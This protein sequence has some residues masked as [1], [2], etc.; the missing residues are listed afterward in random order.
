MYRKITTT[1][2][3]P[4]QP[5]ISSKSSTGH[6]FGMLWYQGDYLKSLS[7]KYPNWPVFSVRIFS[8]SL[9]VINTPEFI[10]GILGNT[11]SASFYPFHI[12]FTNRAL[13]A[14]QEIKDIVA[15]NGAD[16]RY[17]KAIHH[18]M[19]NA[20]QLGPN[21]VET[22]RRVVHSFSQYFNDID[23]SPQSRKLFDWIKLVYT[24]SLADSFYGPENPIR[25]NPQF[26]KHIWDFEEELP[27]LFL[28][29]FPSITARKAW[30]ARKTLTTAFEEYYNKGLDRNAN[31]FIAGRARAA[32]AE[33]FTNNDLAGFE[34]T[35]CFAALTNTVPNSFSMLCNIFT[36]PALTA[37]IREEVS[38]VVTR[39]SVDGRTV[40]SLDTTS[41]DTSC[42]ILISAYNETLRMCVNATAVRVVMEDMVLKDTYDLKKGGIVQIPGGALHESVR[43][44][45]SDAGVFNG[46]RFLNKKDLGR[47]QRKAQSQG[48]FPFGGGKHLCPGRHLAFSEITSFVAMM[49]YGFEIKMKD[50]GLISPPPFKVQ[51]MG[52]NSK[53]PKYDIEVVMSR[54]KEFEGMV[55]AFHVG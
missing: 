21:L 39:T 15:H 19:Y 31:A 52:E 2:E 38:R 55:W 47:E 23:T 13:G 1:A 41:L 35:I 3:N 53:K 20:L 11:K 51:Q 45:G 16:N 54:R 29:I 37:D 44:W 6:L 36:N 18:E 48:L 5:P 33:N 26:V 22:N 14:R 17:M 30:N 8:T 46:R 24:M 10:Q 43:I 42:P 34:I 9:Y 25:E 12:A 7:A 28:N 4:R 50:G 27:M 49:I 40:I 32:R